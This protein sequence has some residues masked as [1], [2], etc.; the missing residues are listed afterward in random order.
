MRPMLLWGM[1]LFAGCASP[2]W[3]VVRRATQSPIG[4]THTIV[5]AEPI[6]G[7]LLVNGV[8]ETEFTKEF[9]PEQQRAWLGLLDIARRGMVEGLVQHRG[10]LHVEPSGAP[11]VELVIQ[12]VLLA[13]QDPHGT[14]KMMLKALC[15][16]KRIDGSVA[17]EIAITSVVESEAVSQEMIDATRTRRFQRAGIDIGTQ[18]AA[19]VKDRAGVSD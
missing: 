14:P 13:N 17:D 4:P 18:A 11:A 10:G 5:V 1:V 15:R 12:E 3:Q 16:L 8:S 7:E 6:T 9:T 19:Y 2:S